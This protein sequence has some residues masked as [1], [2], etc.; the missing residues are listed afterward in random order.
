MLAFVL[1][2]T[3]VVSALAALVVLYLVQGRNA[4]P[5]P[6]LFN[7][8][9]DETVFLFD[10]Q[11]LVDATEAARDLLAT[12]SVEGGPWAQLLVWLTPHFPDIQ[13]RMAQL[14]TLGQ[15]R[16]TAQGGRPL[17]LRAEWRDGLARIT[18]IDTEAEGQVV[19]L[20]ALSHRA[21]GDELATLRA[22][23]EHAPIIVWRED[24][25]G[26][27][28]WANR[29]Y[30]DQAAKTAR[31]GLKWP[32]PRL[33]PAQPSAD[34]KQRRLQLQEAPSQKEGWFDCTS[35]P[36]G[37]DRLF[38]AVPVDSAVQAETAL[39]SFMQTLGKTF[40]H[41]PIGLAIFDRHRRLQL[42]NPALIDLTALGPEFLSA[43]PTL[44]AFLDQLRD[45]Q[46][47][48]EPKD[49]KAWRQ[50]FTGME[51]AAAPR[52]Y[53]E[54][55]ALPSG[56]TYRV[57]GRPHTDGAVAFLVEDITAEIALTR[58]FRA[59]LETGQ[60]V[61]DTLEE[62][63]VV[64][65]PAGIVTMSNRAYAALWG[66]DPAATLAEVGLSESLRH[67]QTHCVPDG[68]WGDLPRRIGMRMAWRGTTRLRDGRTLECRMAPLTGGGVLLGFS[69]IQE[70][71]VQGLMG[72]SA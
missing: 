3:S 17:E 54:T 11:R 5:A 2:S 51:S 30:L 13:A 40:A 7:V 9:E 15:F 39:R 42:F 70:V 64:F 18:L 16:C 31:E 34:D 36:A 10:D 66:T 67:W 32:L 48:P 28:V 49:Y 71:Q 22:T 53:E 60:A 58:R 55:W 56:Q 23:V 45:K 43:R 8:A 62:A 69:A 21:T 46:M 57:T 59:D 25:A 37:A 6:S 61:L 12:S 41:L 38:F 4:G 50:Q 24:P 65:S 52:P 68:P 29:A 14:A 72:I 20:D 44:A 19:T 26:A 35:V 63:I 47:L 1:V 33:F 27:V